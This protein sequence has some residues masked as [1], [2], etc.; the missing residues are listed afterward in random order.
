MTVFCAVR[1]ARYE[2]S[3]VMPSDERIEQIQRSLNELLVSGSES[4]VNDAA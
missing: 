3:V 2:V 1:D 4:T